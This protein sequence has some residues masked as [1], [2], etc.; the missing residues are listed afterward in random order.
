MMRHREEERIL[1]ALKHLKYEIKNANE[2]ISKKRE[3]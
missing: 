3:K 2:K 1:G